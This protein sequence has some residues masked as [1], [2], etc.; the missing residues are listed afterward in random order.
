MTAA[1]SDSPSPPDPEH[2]PDTSRELFDD[3]LIRTHLA[4]ERTFLAWLRTA[5]VLLGVGLGAIA[6]GGS[7]DFEEAVALVLGGVSVVAALV[8]VLWAYVSFGS[9]TAGIERARHRP[10]RAVIATAAA[11]IAVIALL[12]VEALD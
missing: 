7:G 4:N 9:T 8:M 10:P 1:A 2:D 5:V 11:L 6:L 12:A 3:A